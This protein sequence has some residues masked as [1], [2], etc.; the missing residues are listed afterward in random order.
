MYQELK[1]TLYG[2][3]ATNPY[4]HHASV[5]AEAFWTTDDPEIGLEWMASGHT[6][7]AQYQ[8]K[9]NISFSDLEDWQTP[10]TQ[11]ITMPAAPWN[12]EGRYEMVF[13]WT[14]VIT[15][16]PVASGVLVEY[17]SEI[18]LFNALKKFQFDPD[19]RTWSNE[20]SAEPNI[21]QYDTSFAVFD[22]QL[23]SCNA[24]GLYT[25]INCSSWI[26]LQ[27][28]F[29]LNYY[30]VGLGT[31]Q[32][33]DTVEVAPAMIA[34]SGGTMF[35]VFGQGLF[36][37]G[38][39]FDW[40]KIYD[41]AMIRKL[42]YFK[43]KL[44]CLDSNGGLWNAECRDEMHQVSWNPAST[45][46]NPNGLHILGSEMWYFAGPGY[47]VNEGKFWWSTNGMAWTKEVGFAPGNASY[48]YLASGDWPCPQASVN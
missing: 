21:G 31:W 15:D 25:T 47:G 32:H 24:S 16:S 10:K 1:A 23:F 11:E 35:A 17:S 13:N 3:S 7:E 14:R 12:Q 19:S 37:S 22:N 46:D 33:L 28:F 40:Y 43:N 44:W 39:L 42:Y 20:I 18:W 34:S 36:Y 45:L 38:N 41:P 6:C 26:R 30:S 9:F 48:A 5:E 4:A 29:L 2:V 27:N 8:K